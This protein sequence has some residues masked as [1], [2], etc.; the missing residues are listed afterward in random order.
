MP[1]PTLAE[2]ISKER[3]LLVQ[4]RAKIDKA[5]ETVDEILRGYVTVVASDYWR[6]IY[7]LGSQADIDMRIA[8]RYPF[9]ECLEVLWNNGGEPEFGF[10]TLQ[11]TEGGHFILLISFMSVRR[12]TNFEYTLEQLAKKLAERSID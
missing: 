7:A 10:N 1:K 4:Q 2:L 9:M 5:K 3:N 6:T 11:F 12:T 8:A